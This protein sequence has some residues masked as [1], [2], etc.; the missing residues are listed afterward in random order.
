VAASYRPGEE[1]PAT[2]AR[3]GEAAKLVGPGEQSRPVSGK[4]FE[5][6]RATGFYELRNASGAWPMSVSLLSADET[7]LAGAEAVDNRRPISQGQSPARWLTVLA[8]VVLTGE[9]LLYHRR[10]VG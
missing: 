8:I 2:G 10:K 3:S 4:S 5:L 1:A 9:S 6:P 7:L